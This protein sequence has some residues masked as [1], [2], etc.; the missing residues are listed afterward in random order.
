MWLDTVDPDNLPM[1]RLMVA[2]DVGTAITGA[3]RG[4]IFWG[5]GEDAFMKAAR[6]RSSGGYF[7]FVP[8]PGIAGPPAPPAAGDSA[9][10]EAAK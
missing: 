5:H 9:R 4:D 10:G 3:V 7:V 2:Q 6:M 1:Q 8:Q